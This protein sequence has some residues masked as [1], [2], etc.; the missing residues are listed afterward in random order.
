MN[1]PIY[2]RAFVTERLTNQA[3]RTPEIH[4]ALDSITFAGIEFGATL[5]EIVPQGPD[6]RQALTALEQAVFWAKK[7]VTLNQ[8][9]VD[10]ES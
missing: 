6:L 4:V 3:P 10:P 9:A 7:A 5:T 8:S 2:D 1:F